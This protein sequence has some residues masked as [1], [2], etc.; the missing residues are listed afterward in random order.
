MKVERIEIGTVING[1]I[2][3]VRFLKNIRIINVTSKTAK[4]SV[5][6]T[7]FKAS[8][9]SSSVISYLIACYQRYKGFSFWPVYIKT[10]IGVTGLLT[11]LFTYF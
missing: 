4:Q 5:N 11:I 1:I 3:L 2:V 10:F 8:N 9:V 6:I 7:S